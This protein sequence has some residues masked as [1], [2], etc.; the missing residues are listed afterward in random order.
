M[1][2]CK[3]L[4]SSVRAPSHDRRRKMRYALQALAMHSH[5][6]RTLLLL[7]ATFS[8]GLACAADP[9]DPLKT[10]N[11]AALA[12]GSSSSSGSGRSSSGS[13]SSGGGNSGSGTGSGAGS[14]GT[15]NSSGSGT[16]SG[17]S[18]SGSSTGSS[19]GSSGSSGGSGGSDGGPDGSAGGPTCITSPKSAAVYYYTQ[20]KATST[21]VQTIQFNLQIA[22]AGF[23]TVSLSDVTV[24][25]WFTADGNTLSGITFMTY[26]SSNAGT[27]ITKSIKPTFAAAPPANTTATSDTYLELAFGTG[28]GSIAALSGGGADVQVAFHGPYSPPAPFNETNDYSFDS[29]KTTTYHAWTNIT[30]Y[31]K[32]QLVWG[33]EPG[34]G[35]TVSAG[36]S[37]SSSSGGGGDASG[38]SGDAG[39]GSVGDGGGESGD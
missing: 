16:G 39:G 32:G 10:G 14:S 36:G 25:Y 15:G 27:D 11:G 5:A 12:G 4:A 33:C 37:S 18:G 8:L 9:G 22:N 17:G 7:G 28:T 13:A 29:T 26:Y 21:S 6:A 2:Y 24:R 1:S 35:G 38:A 3:K 20:D 30:A 23:S 34:A 19:G 31:L